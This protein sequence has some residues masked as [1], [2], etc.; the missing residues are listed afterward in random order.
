MRSRDVRSLTYP[1]ISRG[2]RGQRASKSD[3]F[4]LALTLLGQ[5]QNHEKW[6]LHDKMYFHSFILSAHFKVF[7]IPVN[8]YCQYY[9]LH[10]TLFFRSFFVSYYSFWSNYCYNSFLHTKRVWAESSKNIY[11]AMKLLGSCIKAEHLHK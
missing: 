10:R 4:G 1:L 7:D 6:N 9:A 2:N 8:K 11:G 3:H 5:P